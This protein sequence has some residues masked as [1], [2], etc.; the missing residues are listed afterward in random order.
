MNNDVR[1]AAVQVAAEQ[2][3]EKPEAVSVNTATVLSRYG[4]VCEDADLVVFPELSLTGYIPLKGYDQR[5]KRILAGVARQVQETELPA[6][7]AATSGKRAALVVGFAELSI[8][9]N[10]FYNAV[11]CIED[12]EILGVYRKIHL[13][14]E[15]NHYFIPGDTVLTVISRVGRIALLACY[16]IMFPEAARLA[17]LQGAEILVAPSNWLDIHNLRLAGEVL[18]VARALEQQM[19]V[20]LVNGVGTLSARGR[21]WELYG[22]SRIVS[23]TGEVIATAGDGEQTVMGTLT[24]DA[25]AAG[26]DVFP[27]LRD[28][29]P[30]RYATIVAPLSTFAGRQAMTNTSTLP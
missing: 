17:A 28:R 7:V 25:L 26:S 20:V 2:C 29:R 18:P 1:V 23:A 30:E 9:R 16:D 19:H 6:L 14:V 4:E 27:L 10:E 12:G 11:A 8:M 5:R 24:S 13:P 21:R 15:E 3:W 22:R